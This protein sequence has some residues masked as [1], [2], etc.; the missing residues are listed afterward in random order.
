MNESVNESMMNVFVEQPLALPRSAKNCLH[1]NIFQLKNL[2]FNIKMTHHPT[3]F[4]NTNNS[5]KVLQNLFGEAL[6]LKI[7]HT[8][9]TESL[10]QCG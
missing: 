6:T 7:L 8:G 2:D 1:F 3:T 9:D 5:R 4:G 10:G